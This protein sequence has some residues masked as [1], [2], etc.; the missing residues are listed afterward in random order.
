M[1]AHI[2][3]PTHQESRT[4]SHCVGRDGNPKRSYPTEE[5]ADSAAEHRWSQGGPRLR[6]YQ[7]PW[8]SAWHLT[9]S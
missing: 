7:C 3:I 1:F 4:C 6:A 5:A 2:C 9:K 8:T